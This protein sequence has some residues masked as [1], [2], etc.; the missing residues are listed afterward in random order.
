MPV[1]DD[2]DYLPPDKIRALQTRQEVINGLKSSCEATERFWKIWQKQYLTSL[3][4]KQ[5]TL[6]TNRRQGQVIPKTGD[7][8][9]IC[10]PVLPRNDWRVARIT[11]V[12]QE[13]DGFIREVELFTSTHREIRRPVNLIIPLEIE[14][15]DAENDS[16]DQI[17]DNDDEAQ[18]GK[19][20]AEQVPAR[21]NLRPR[22]PVNYTEQTINSISTQRPKPLS[23]KWFCFA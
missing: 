6:L 15:H 14:S 5:K 22:R 10:D 21:Y 17:E 20:A 1:E 7:V 12:K 4:E 19:S 13:T 2:P 18:N 9:L 16:N 23:A 3:R 8:V 11:D